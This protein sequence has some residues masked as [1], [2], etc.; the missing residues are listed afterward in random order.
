[1]QVIKLAKMK[2]NLQQIPLFNTTELCS[3]SQPP[4]DWPS[5]HLD[6]RLLVQVITVPQKSSQQ[7]QTT[8]VYL[9]LNM[10]FS[11][12]FMYLSVRGEKLNMPTWTIRLIFSDPDFFVV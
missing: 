5:L 2:G 4:Q 11:S 9:V 12:L 6:T 8:L 3:H 1:M 10:K 7:K